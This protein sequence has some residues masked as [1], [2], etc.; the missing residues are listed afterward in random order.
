MKSLAPFWFK[1]LM[2]LGCCCCCCCCSCC[3]CCNFDVS[4]GA[5]ANFT[6]ATPGVVNNDGSVACVTFFFY[7]FVSVSVCQCVSVCVCVFIW[8]FCLL[9]RWQS[10]GRPTHPTHPHTHTH[11]H[12]DTRDASCWILVKL[13]DAETHSAIPRIKPLLFQSSFRA[14]SEQ[15]QSSSRALSVQSPN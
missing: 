11:V 9:I 3:F 4:L 1:L 5:A 7:L 2:N 6:H 10:V 14:V 8:L 13:A 12:T 15:F